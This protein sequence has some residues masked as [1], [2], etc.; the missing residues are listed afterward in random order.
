M[1]V[2]ISVDMEGVAGISDFVAT[3]SPEERADLAKALAPIVAREEIAPMCI[4][5]KDSTNA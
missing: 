4:A 2:F 5:R 1:K 3:L